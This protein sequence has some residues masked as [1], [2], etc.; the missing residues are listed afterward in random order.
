MCMF[1]G[2]VEIAK[3]FKIL[4]ASSKL[5][6]VAKY[7]MRMVRYAA[8][9]LPSSVFFILSH[10]LTGVL[11][12][13]ICVSHFSMETIDTQFSA[14]GESWV[15]H[16]CRTTLDIARNRGGSCIPARENA[17]RMS[18]TACGEGRSGAISAVG[19]SRLVRWLASAAN[20]SGAGMARRTCALRIV[21]MC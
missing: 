18:A 3:S 19:V 14:K 11:H 5:P 4:R 20:N 10:A 21:A 1:D 6:L 9:R 16:Q 2:D 8:P 13:Q 17:F 12:I 7:S 15:E